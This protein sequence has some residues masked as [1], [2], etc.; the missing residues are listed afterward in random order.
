MDNENIQ[1]RIEELEQLKSTL[2]TNYANMQVSIPRDIDEISAI[3]ES[4]KR[5]LEP[6]STA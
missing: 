4:Y 3:I 6:V 1:K 5:R 2:Q